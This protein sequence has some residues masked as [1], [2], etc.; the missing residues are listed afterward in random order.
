MRGGLA[1]DGGVNRQN[2]FAHVFVGG[3]VDQL[4]DG[5]IFGPHTLDRRQRAAQH[6]IEP[7]PCPCPFQRPEIAHL[8]DDADDGAVAA[9][10]GT[11]GARIDGIDIAAMAA[12]CHLVAHLAQGAG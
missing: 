3:P 2:N 4:G 11:Q 5:Q 7:L 1:L 9:R 6:M 10:I 8:L 12:H